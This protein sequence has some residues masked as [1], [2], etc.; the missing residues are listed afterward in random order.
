MLPVQQ[1]IIDRLAKVYMEIEEGCC[2][3]LSGSA[4]MHSNDMSRALAVDMHCLHSC[5]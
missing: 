1:F 3:A 4:C 2:F 5:S